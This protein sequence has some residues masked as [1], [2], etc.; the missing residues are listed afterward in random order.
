MVLLA[1]CNPL[2]SCKAQ[3]TFGTDYLKFEKV[4]VMP[5]LK[6]RIDHMD[7]NLKD[8]TIYIAALGNNTVEVVDIENGKLV[9]SIKGLDKPQGVGY[10]PQTNEI[11]IANGGNGDCY[12]YN[13]ASFLQT[14]VVHLGSDADDVRYDSVSQKIYVGYGDGGIAMIDAATHQQTGDV[15]L[16]AHPEGFQLDKKANLLLA[17]LPDKNMIAAID[18]MQLKLISKWTRNTP[19]ANFPMA[20]DTVTQAAFIGYRHPA[21]LVILNSKTGKET[22]NC[23][24]VNDVDDLYFDDAT[25]RIYVSGGGGFINIFQQDEKASYKQIA[26]IATSDGARTSLLIPRLKL[27]VV[28]ERARAGKVAQLM[29]YTT[30]Q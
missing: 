10:I 13:A 2:I 16:P 14:A 19:T 15:K 27:F 26:N 5:G 1:L 28:A 11:F 22:G 30:S 17:N 20:V 6:G 3:P 9:H 23:L 7:V 25:K 12:F 8:K 4:I 18:L 29:I 24:M 21:K